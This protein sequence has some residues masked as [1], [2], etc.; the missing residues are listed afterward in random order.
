MVFENN[1]NEGNSSCSTN[2]SHEEIKTILKSGEVY[3]GEHSNYGKLAA[4][5]RHSG[6]T[7]ADFVEVTPYVSHSKTTKDAQKFWDS[8]GKYS[9]ITKGTLMY[10]IHHNK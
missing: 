7:L 8:W 5:M 2:L 10:M 3:L 6:F 1:I 4:A 9:D